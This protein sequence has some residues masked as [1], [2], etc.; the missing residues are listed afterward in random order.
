[1]KAAGVPVAFFRAWPGLSPRH[2]ERGVEL[3]EGG[4]GQAEDPFLTSV[5]HKAGSDDHQQPGEHV[6]AV[7]PA[8][9]EVKVFHREREIADRDARRSH[10]EQ[11]RS[12]HPVGEVGGGARQDQQA[13][14]REKYG[15]CA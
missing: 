13:G 6:P 10:G 5:E 9:A 15:P 12:R 3:Q 1:M 4:D 14:R 11:V 7:E 2:G 8:A